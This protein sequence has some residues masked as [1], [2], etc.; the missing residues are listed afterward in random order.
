[1]G[2]YG[3]WV[4]PG[5]CIVV[6]RRGL[7]Y[8]I[9]IHKKKWIAPTSVAPLSRMQ[10]LCK[11]RVEQKKRIWNSSSVVEISCPSAVSSASH[12]NWRSA[13]V[14]VVDLLKNSIV[15]SLVVSVL[16]QDWP[17]KH[18]YESYKEEVSLVSWW[19]SHYCNGCERLVLFCFPYVFFCY[20]FG[21]QN[22]L[23]VCTLTLDPKSYTFE[24]G[25]GG[26]GL[27]FTHSF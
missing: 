25:S 27:G 17:G 16:V 9:S 2:G 20:V 23:H 18:M 4:L 12:I 24:I 14:T 8:H 7:V 26:K 19:R 5:C 13:C 3:G 10:A 1:M 15:A 21:A 6:H 11:S 22:P